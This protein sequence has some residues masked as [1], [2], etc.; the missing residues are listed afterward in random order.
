MKKLQPIFENIQFFEPERGKM[1]VKHCR[2][3]R[4]AQ[5]F[6]PNGPPTIVVVVF[7]LFK[8]FGLFFR[9]FLSDLQVTHFDTGTYFFK[10]DLYEYIM[11][12]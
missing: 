12:C 11:E 1:T 5:S 7:L 10:Y 4:I 8:D 3:T 9:Y 6:I 2:D